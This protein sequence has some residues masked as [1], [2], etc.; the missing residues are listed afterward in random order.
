MS[1]AKKA[2]PCSA[3]ECANNAEQWRVAGVA[4]PSCSGC[5][6]QLRKLL[7][8]GMEST[9]ALEHMRRRRKHTSHLNTQRNA[10]NNS[11]ES[12]EKQGLHPADI[13]H[14]ARHEN[15][16]TA[17]ADP[18]APINDSAGRSSQ[19]A[20]MATADSEATHGKRKRAKGTMDSDHNG[21]I[22]WG[23]DSDS[24][25]PERDGLNAT[26][27]RRGLS[28]ARVLRKE[29]LQ[30][31][32]LARAKEQKLGSIWVDTDDEDSMDELSL[33]PR[34]NSASTDSTCENANSLKQASEARGQKSKATACLNKKSAS[35]PS[36]G[37]LLVDMRAAC[38]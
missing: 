30:Q 1:K 38:C 6:R 37:Q 11:V 25:S 35:P 18:G 29:Q 10:S 20:H 19:L 23:D 17:D 3:V 14:D 2:V 36:I 16:N 26:L 24:D 15:A 33:K 21:M 5:A 13:S 8:E 27:A 34:K 31:D 28:Q 4:L 9:E 22:D 32:A 12:S 7:A